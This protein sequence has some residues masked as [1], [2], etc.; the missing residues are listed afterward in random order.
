MNGRKLFLAATAIV[1]VAVILFA[2]WI[3]HD[4]LSAKAT[5]SWVETLVA[6][7]F[8]SQ[9]REGAEK[10]GR[11]LCGSTARCAVALRGSLR[12]VPWE[13]RQRRHDD[14]PRPLSQATGPARC[15]HA[16]TLGW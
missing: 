4:G 14:G 2:R 6:A 3:L 12:G 7:P 8:Y 13:R 10:P 11:G 16:E 9:R 1:L 15:T 5:P